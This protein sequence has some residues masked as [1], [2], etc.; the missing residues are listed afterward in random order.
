MKD[1][2]LLDYWL[3]LYRKKRLILVITLASMIT[4][5][6]IS[7]VLS[8]VYESKSGFFVPSTPDVMS[9]LSI[10]DS[11]NVVRT[12]LVPSTIE[13][14]HAPYIGFLKS[15]KIRELV[16]KEF[17]HKSIYQLRKDVDFSLSDEYMIEIYSK[18]RDPVYAAGIANAY[19]DKLNQLI[20]GF[21][22]SQSDRNQATIAQEIKRTK[23]RLY[24]AKQK[25][26][27]FQE[28]NGTLVLD[29]EKTQLISQKGDFLYKLE[30][31]KVSEYEIDGKIE[32]LKNQME[33]ESALF[34]SSKFYFTSPLLTD[35]RKEL[36]DIEIKMAGLKV[37]LRESHP[38][39]ITLKKQSGQ[40]KENI[41][42]E[43]KR[44]VNS[45]IKAPHTFHEKIRQDLVNLLIDKQRIQSS[46][47]AYKTVIEGIETRIRNLP[48]LFIIFDTLTSTV[49]KY[50]AMLQSLELKFEEIKMQKEKNM[51]LVVMVEEAR[52]STEPSFPVM[53]LNITVAGLAGL[54]AGIFYSF[55]INYLEETREQRL[56]KL[57]KNLDILEK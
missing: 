41:N 34:T 32:G 6:T 54:I 27:E 42:F 56:F 29:D 15:K 21:S 13:E 3:I 19:V 31:A 8:P 55:F 20:A 1:L 4:A 12:P 22:L 51:Q 26:K 14:F 33:K 47:L 44:I 16:Q 9:Y 53:G 46:I 25:L 43:I 30:S 2:T 24:E 52:P 11:R 23:D 5:G 10:P 50:R 37:E 38:D 28:K 45:Q 48:E 57:L 39:F 36:S 40:I 35:L 7:S 18:D 49:E 17:P